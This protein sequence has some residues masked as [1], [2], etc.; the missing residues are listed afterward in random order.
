MCIA[1]ISTAHP[2]YQLILIDNRD[3]YLNRPTAPASY[4]PD[5]NSHVIGGR[6]LLRSVQGTWLGVTTDGR[7]AVLTNFREEGVQHE[8]AISRGVIIRSFLTDS[9]SSSTDEFVKRMIA[10][11]TGRDAGG[12][13]L[14]CGRIG[15]PLAVMSNRAKCEDDIPWIAAKSGETVGLSN[16]AFGDRSWHKVAQG[17]R[18]MHDTIAESIESDESEDQLVNRL[19]GLLSTDTLLPRHG[20]EAG[21]EMYINELRN[22]IFVPAIGKKDPPGLPADEVATARTDEKAAVLE[23]SLDNRLP[24]GVS[25]LYGTQ[26]QSV[27]LV[28]HSG[29][30]RFIERTLYDNDI[31]PIPLGNG[32]LEFVFEIKN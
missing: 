11:G 27:I 29:R 23:G 15:E 28:S 6:D 32:D 13:S 3:E 19:L 22:S 25:G 9:S 12:F 16:A 1:L 10:S 24:L 4:W 5:P 21:L 30:V 7:I 2:A 20:D 31:K 26:K 17:E 14:V 18:S 8:G